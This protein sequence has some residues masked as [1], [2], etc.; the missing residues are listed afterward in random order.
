MFVFSPTIL[1]KFPNSAISWF[2]R[3]KNRCLLSSFDVLIFIGI[4]ICLNLCLLI[5]IIC[6]YLQLFNVFFLSL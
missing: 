5:H 4:F 2:F 6:K 1:V 3:Y